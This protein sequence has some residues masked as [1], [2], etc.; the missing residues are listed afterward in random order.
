MADINDINANVGKLASA[1]EEL[2][3]TNDQRLAQLESKGSADVLTTEKL[4]RI[5]GE[6]SALQSAVSDIAKKSN[7]IGA[8]DASVQDD[9]YK[10]AFD[11]WARKGD[12]FQDELEA[13]ALVTNDTTGGFL[14]P[15]T[16]EAGIRDDLRTLSPI[17]AEATVIS[18]SNDR[19]TFLKNNHGLTT[20]WVG[21]TD[22]RPE[23]ATPTLME[24]TLPGG[25]IY[26]NP[27]VSQRALDDSQ[28]N[29]EAWLQNEITN[30]MAIAE[31]KAFVNGDGVNKPKGFAVEP[32]LTTV[33]T[34]FAATMP[35]GTDYLF[36]MIYSMPAAYRAGAK[37][38]SNGAVSASLRTAKDSQGNYIW[39]P[40]LVLGQPASI[41]GFAH[42]ELEDMDAIA[43]G[44]VPLAFANMK[45]GYTVA[46]RIGVRTIRDPYTHKPFV[47]FYA[48]KRV[49]G[50]VTDAK[51]FVV[52]KVQA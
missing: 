13:K 26:A 21:E 33:K 11:K 47:H 52:L 7:R 41:A 42:V 3:S 30:E 29:L 27:A 1:F 23:T 24:V 6:M 50:M 5:N 22:A 25:E 48:T 39:Q 4:E 20:G 51:A 40:S 12:R 9:E 17:R 36:N 45:Q 44:K 32:G 2:K 35:V 10:S 49:S 34:G 46:D 18:T 37:F 15:K 16:V 28:F 8:S 31:S 43:A 19:Y 14:V 38:Y